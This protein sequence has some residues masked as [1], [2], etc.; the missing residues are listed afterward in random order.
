LEKRNCFKGRRKNM[1][2]NIFRNGFVFG[3]IFLFLG[4]GIFPTISGS[5][6]SK[7]K[8][9]LSKSGLQ[10]TLYTNLL[11]VS[12]TKNIIKTEDYLEVINIFGFWITKGQ[13][14]GF[15]NTNET[16]YIY[17]FK[18]I[19]IRPIVIGMCDDYNTTY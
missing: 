14:G 18:G 7:Y 3:I 13:H 6:E 1:Q 4:A 2:K 19:I 11:V 9:D 8:T 15:F 17:G 12:F 10:L 5:I 16:I